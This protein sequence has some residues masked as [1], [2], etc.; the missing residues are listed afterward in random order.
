MAPTAFL[1]VLP[2]AKQQFQGSIFL[3]GSPQYSDEPIVANI[4]LENYVA[5]QETFIVFGDRKITKNIYLSSPTTPKISRVLSRDNQIAR[6]SAI[7]GDINRDG[8]PDLIIGFPFS[9]KCFVYF[10]TENGLENLVVSFVVYGEVDSEFGWAV[11]GFGDVNN[12]RC[13]DFMISAKAIGVI[14]IL[15]G[16]EGPHQN[17]YVANLELDQGFKITGASGTFN[18][19]GAVAKGGDFNRDG[20]NE[21]IFSSMTES[22][23]GIVY[24]V[25]GNETFRDVSLN[26][27]D[28]SNSILKIVCPV[29]SFSGL[30]LAGVGDINNDGFD[31]IAIGSLPFRG[32]Y[33]TQRTYLIYG[34]TLRD[35]VEFINLSEMREGIDGVT[36]IGGGFLVAGPGDLNGDGI[37][38]MMVVNYPSWQGQSNSYFIRFPENVTSSPTALPSFFPSSQPSA[39]PSFTPTMT[40]TTETPS[41]R[42]STLTPTRIV[43]LSM[44]FPP[45]T[46]PTRMPKST[47]A[48][49]SV[50]PTLAPTVVTS[51]IPTRIPNLSPSSAIPSLKTETLK[52]S[53]T[54]VRS[55][56]HPSKHRG[57]SISTPSLNPTLR[58]TSFSSDFQIIYC[59]NTEIC[60]GSPNINT[61]FILQSEGTVRTRCASNER[62]VYLILPMADNVIIIEE[63]SVFKDMIDLSKFFWIKS[64]DDLSFS[65]NPQVIFLGSSQQIFFPGN[66]DVIHF[67]VDNFYFISE[68]ESSLNSNKTVYQFA[69]IGL[70]VIFLGFVGVILE[71]KLEDDIKEIEKNK[72]ELE[73]LQQTETALEKGKTNMEMLE[74]GG[75]MLRK[76]QDKPDI[77]TQGENVLEKNKDE[78]D[79]LEDGE[80]MLKENE[81][82]MQSPLIIADVN[83]EP[84]EGND[85]I[86]IKSND[87]DNDNNSQ[88]HGKA[89]TESDGEITSED[90][91]ENE[92]NSYLGS[93]TEWFSS[94]QSG[95]SRNSSNL[96]EEGSQ[97][98]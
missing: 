68:D 7:V 81:C 54:R 76:N 89:S 33:Q 25:F 93:F 12:D 51:V 92:S 75:N 26:Q 19:G 85:E 39:A 28:S 38:D 97:S 79:K 29:A 2:N 49:K 13:A 78:L 58:N 53:V 44:S 22:S 84:V 46:I 90:E 31:D 11:S 80:N 21:I 70:M 41:N 16:K 87:E 9:S 45:Q 18:T 5:K 73:I 96:S 82:S 57:S 36:I 42:P 35:R 48:P 17:I 43:N 69:M 67:T 60:R 20:Y 98:H 23:Q 55:S 6:S 14:Y 91:N 52:P 63:F 10:G 47:L 15:F 56:A 64:I 86:H 30:S 74:E 88:N 50:R 34:K 77:L 3:L 40:Q 71:K 32:S 24:V 61:Q 1:S 94:N 62:C 59:N 4:N 66:K 83:E 8:H 65:T 27:L 72:N 37:A 95:Y